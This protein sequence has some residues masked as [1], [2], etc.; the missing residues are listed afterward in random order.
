MDFL[1]KDDLRTLIETQGEWCISLFLPTVRAGSETQQNPIRFKNLL[2]TAEDRLTDLGVRK[3]AEFL[4]SAHDLFNNTD[5]WRNQSDGLAAFLAEDFFQTYR[6]PTGFS[7]LAVVTR[8]FHLKPLLPWLGH[9][10]RFYVLALSQDEIRLLEGTRASVHTVELNGVPTNIDDALQED[11][12]HQ[13][14]FRLSSGS[15]Q[16]GDSDEGTGSDKENK[17]RL[18]RYFHK[19]DRGLRDLLADERIPL[20]LA[21]VDYLLPIYREANTYGKLLDDDLKSGNP[22]ILSPKELHKMAWEK[23]IQPYYGRE[24]NKQV[25]LYK[26]LAGRN[27]V[28]AAD[29]LKTILHAAHQGRIATLFVAKGTR[30]WGRFSPRSFTIHAHPERQPDDQD[31][32][33]LAAVQTY[34]NGG[35]VYVVE[36][37][38]VPSGQALAAVFRY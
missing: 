20:V 26:E 17:A 35:T 38:N 2:R 13:A 22:E 7:E 9:D 18:L 8:R 36:P 3:P 5:F 32:F 37:D 33:D 11:N 24:Y 23:V 15:G 25:D 31:L 27:A 29:D 6:L 4:Q 19:V 1:T 12:Q 30:Q 14:H 28:E 21:G 10:D 34:I 16:S